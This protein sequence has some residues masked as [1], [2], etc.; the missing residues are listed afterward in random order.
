MKG[1]LEIA[2]QQKRKKKKNIPQK[3]NYQDKQVRS[4]IMLQTSKIFCQH[5]KPGETVF[6]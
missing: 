6:H 5:R 3:S 4:V 2:Q 1:K